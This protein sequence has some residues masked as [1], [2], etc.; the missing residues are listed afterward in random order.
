MSDPFTRMKLGPSRR[1]FLRGAAAAGGAAVLPASLGG[2]EAFAQGAGDTLVIAAPATPQGL[3][4]EFDV[5]VGSIDTLGAI[6]EYMLAY[7]KI[8]APN[9]HGVLC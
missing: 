7:E 4:I 1:Q 6:Y 2:N 8:A 3:D 5:S 9:G